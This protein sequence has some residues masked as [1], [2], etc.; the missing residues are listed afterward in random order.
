M[1][2][3]T[4]QRRKMENQAD[5]ESIAKELMTAA[6]LLMKAVIEIKAVETKHGSI[7]L[8]AKA[9]RSINRGL[10]DLKQGNYAVYKDFNSFRKSFG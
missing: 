1:K 5:L 8:S 4:L 7:K 9:Q 10:R 2:T 3:T 6:N